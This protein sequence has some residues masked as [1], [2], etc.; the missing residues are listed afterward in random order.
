MTQEQEQTESLM[1]KLK[2]RFPNI[3]PIYAGIQNLEHPQEM[4]QFID[5]YVGLFEANPHYSHLDKG[6]IYKITCNSIGFGT[7][8]CSHDVA[9]RWFAIMESDH[10]FFGST[11]IS[12]EE[13]NSPIP[14]GERLFPETE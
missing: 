5:E 6:E 10:P 4:C 2:E 12:D 9:R 1:E 8:Y 3:A 11:H 13:L 14:F 7:G